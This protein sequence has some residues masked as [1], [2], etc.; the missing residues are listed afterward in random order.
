MAGLDHTK[1]EKSNGRA[2]PNLKLKND[3]RTNHAEN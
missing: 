3:D 2:K 1:I